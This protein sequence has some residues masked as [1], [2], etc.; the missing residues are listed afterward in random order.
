M[1]KND[2][3]TATLL[4]DFCVFPKNENIKQKAKTYETIRRLLI[5]HKTL[6]LIM[7]AYNSRNTHLCSPEQLLFF[8]LHVLHVL[9]SVS[10]LICFSLVFQL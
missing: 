3:E 5:V 6:L 7:A 10:F 2:F 8:Y 4:L 9:L 1:I